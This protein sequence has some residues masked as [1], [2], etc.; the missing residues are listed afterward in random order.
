ME[1][2]KEAHLVKVIELEEEHSTLYTGGTV[3]LSHD[4]KLLF[5]QMNDKI[6]VIEV[7]R[8]KKIHTITPVLKPFFDFG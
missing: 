8:G 7:E 2:K 4:E 3:C 6:N 5:C 1:E